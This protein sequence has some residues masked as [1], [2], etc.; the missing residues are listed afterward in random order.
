MR[1]VLLTGATGFVGRHIPSQLVDRGFEVHTL[2][3]RGGCDSID[4]GLIA[5][6]A[7]LFDTVSVRS[8]VRSVA[9]T[10]LLHLAWE[11]APGKFWSSF[12][13]LDWV[14]ASVNLFRAFLD[15]GG[16]RAVF[17]GTCAE[18]Q[19]IDAP[20]TEATTPSRPTT[21]YGSC[22]NAL[23]EIVTAAGNEAH[24]TVSWGRVFFLYGPDEK[25]G[26]LVRDVIDG[27]LAGRR[28][29][30]TWGTQKRDFLHVEDAA[31]AFVAL[32][33]SD[34]SGIVN[35]GS[36]EAVTVRHIVETIARTR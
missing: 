34:V 33:D 3:R 5:H 1:R 9:P 15:A 21:L 4:Q 26:R 31:S 18:Y 7:D 17:A 25:P 28:V 14:A 2:G 12:N 11:T 6:V 35:I 29:E 24:A 13:N 16:R 20:L 22:K 8:I 32:L 10:H 23:R 36:G 30:T 27:L 19:W